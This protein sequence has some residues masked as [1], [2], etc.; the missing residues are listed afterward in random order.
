ME[1]LVP[2]A[3]PRALHKMNAG[4]IDL[5]VGKHVGIVSNG[6]RSMEAMVPRITQRLKDEYGAREVSF[7]TVPLNRPI[8]ADTLDAVEHCD[9]AIVGLAN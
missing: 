3:A 5:L 9:A 8:T 4:A 7:H 2:T 6:W 1:I